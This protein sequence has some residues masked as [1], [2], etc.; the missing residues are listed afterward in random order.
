M[1]DAHARAPPLQAPGHVEKAAKVPA[2][3]GVGAGGEDVV[4]LAVHDAPGNVRVLDA[5]QAAEAATGFRFLAL[6]QLQAPHRGEKLARLLL[7]AHFAQARAAVVVR[8]ATLVFGFDTGDLQHV[9]EKLGKFKGALAEGPRP[10]GHGGVAG[11]KPGEV[12]PDH[13]GTRSRRRHHVIEALEGGDHL[14]RDGA[15]VRLVAGVVGRL[16]AACLRRGNGDHAAGILQELDRGEPHGRPHQID[17]TGNEKADV[18]G[19]RRHGRRMGVSA[20][21]GKGRRRGF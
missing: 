2:E 12:H 9:P 4:H 8:G 3:Q 6:F 13:A 15:G 5:E 16:P 14:A 18:G 1:A 19:R 11:E 7:D 21:Q 20:T 10:P 17:Q